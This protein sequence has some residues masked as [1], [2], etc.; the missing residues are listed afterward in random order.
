[1]NQLTTEQ[2]RDAL[3]RAGWTMNLGAFC[4]ALDWREDDYAK[5]KFV[6]FQEMC[7]LINNFDTQTLDTLVQAG[8]DP[9]KHEHCFQVVPHAEVAFVSTSM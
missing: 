1:M 2:F 6:K 5:D 8:T 7:R 4:K 9:Q 3:S